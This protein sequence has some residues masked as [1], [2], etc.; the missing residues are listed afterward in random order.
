MF[1]EG[2]H[3]PYSEGKGSSPAPAAEVLCV[4]GCPG[5]KPLEEYKDASPA[6]HLRSPLLGEVKKIVG[7]SNQFL[8]SSNGRY[9]SLLNPP[10]FA[11]SASLISGSLVV[12]GS[13]PTLPSRRRTCFAKDGLKYSELRATHVACLRRSTTGRREF[14]ASLFRH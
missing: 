3:P 6:N 4:A 10:L 9:E 2:P 8:I 13:S 12:A 11:L 5:A 14:E 1:S 7:G